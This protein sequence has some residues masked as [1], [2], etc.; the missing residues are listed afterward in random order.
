MKDLIRQARRPSSSS[1]AS[2][3]SVVAEPLPPDDKVLQEAALEVQRL[4]IAAADA[5]VGQGD[6]RAQALGGGW[7]LQHRGN[8]ADAIQGA[9]RGAL[10][11]G[12]LLPLR[13]VCLRD[14]D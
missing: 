9:A 10:G 14:S 8:V 1:S 13:G 4:D 5:A 12:I 2:P 6:F 11:I 3:T 7:T